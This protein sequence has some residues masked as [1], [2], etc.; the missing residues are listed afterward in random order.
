MQVNRHFTSP[1][2][3]P[4][5]I[6]DIP[7]NAICN[8]YGWDQ[9]TAAPRHEEV[10][11]SRAEFC[12]P[13]TPQVS[14][15]T[16]QTLE[17]DICSAR[18][19]SPLF[20]NANSRF[21]GFMISDGCIDDG[22]RIRVN[23]LSTNTF[24]LW[25]DEVLRADSNDRHVSSQFIVNVVEFNSRVSASE[26]F[27]CVGTLINQHHVLTTA[28]CVQTTSNFHFVIGVQATWETIG[29]NVIEPE[30][31]FIHPNFE[32]AQIFTANVAVMR[33]REIF[34]SFYFWIPFDYKFFIERF[35]SRTSQFSDST[36]SWLASNQ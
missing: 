29:R 35:T 2:F 7:S 30:E 28:S 8:L 13:N 31:I 5:G 16:F 6:S 36:N 4:R 26:Q 24:R 19:G 15:S 9:Q 1:S 11:I 20:C 14:C 34:I 23:Y 18:L 3:P 12:N 32:A 25:I 10:L 33:V 27:R 21:S 22:T 17:E